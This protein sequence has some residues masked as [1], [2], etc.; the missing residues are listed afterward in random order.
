MASK[1]NVQSIET[2]ISNL[3]EKL[4]PK[5]Q[6][7]DNNG[8]RCG[9]LERKLKQADGSVLDMTDNRKQIRDEIADIKSN[10]TRQ[11]HEELS[12]V[13]RIYDTEKEYKS[14]MLNL[15]RN[16]LNKLMQ[17]KQNIDNDLLLKQAQF[18]AVDKELKKRDESGIQS[19]D[20]LLKRAQL[21]EHELNDPTYY[22]MDSYKLRM[23]RNRLN[24]NYDL[25]QDIKA[26]MI[27]KRKLKFDEQQNTINNEIKILKAKKKMIDDQIRNV[28]NK[29]KQFE[30]QPVNVG[31]IPTQNDIDQ[32]QHK[33]QQLQLEF[34]MNHR[35]KHANIEQEIDIKCNDEMHVMMRQFV[36]QNIISPFCNRYIVSKS[37]L[38]DKSS[39]IEAE[40]IEIEQE[41]KLL[42][43]KQKQNELNIVFGEIEMELIRETTTEM[44]KHL[45]DQLNGLKRYCHTMTHQVLLNSIAFGNGNANAIDSDVIQMSNKCL[46]QLL[47][48]RDRRNRNTSNHRFVLRHNVSKIHQN[49]INSKPNDDLDEKEKPSEMDH[50]RRLHQ[51][52]QNDGMCLLFLC[53]MMAQFSCRKYL[54]EEAKY[55][56]QFINIQHKID[57]INK[58]RITSQWRDSYSTNYTALIAS[59]D[60]HLVVI[61]TH[62]GEI[63]LYHIA[64]KSIIAR[65]HKTQRKTELNHS[66]I[67][68]LLM[69]SNNKMIVSLTQTGIVCVYKVEANI[70]KQIAILHPEDYYRPSK[71]W[72]KYETMSP[73]QL[74]AHF[75]TF[76][77]FHSCLLINGMRPSIMIGLR[78]GTIVKWNL[79]NTNQQNM[80]ILYAPCQT[81]NEP[82][83]SLYSAISSAEQTKWISRE[84]FEYHASEI[85]FIGFI[86]K[87]SKIMLS[88]DTNGVCCVWFYD[89]KSWADYG[90]GWFIPKHKYNIDLDSFVK[91]PITDTEPKILYDSADASIKSQKYDAFIRQNL[92][93][94]HVF[95]KFKSNP[96]QKEVI[97]H[98]YFAKSIISC[99]KYDQES[100]PFVVDSLVYSTVND[101]LIRHMQRSYYQKRLKGTICGAAFCSNHK[102]VIIAI[103]LKPYDDDERDSK[104]GIIQFRLI[105]YDETDIISVDRFIVNIQQAHTNDWPVWNVSPVLIPPCSDYLY[106]LMSNNLRIYSIHTSQEV[107]NIKHCGSRNNPFCITSNHEY[108]I[109]ANQYQTDKAD[110]NNHCLYLSQIV[111]SN[112]TRMKLDQIFTKVVNAKQCTR[113]SRTN[114]EFRRQKHS[115]LE[116]NN[117]HR[118]KINQIVQDIVNQIH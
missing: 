32:M 67:I 72:T 65:T 117:D 43:R 48:D 25:Q 18:N 111:D 50:K 116:Y 78:N 1:E 38:T 87:L 12:V 49:N 101:E 20:M 10:I 51:K 22:D 13:T 29:R 90:S 102:D 97:E 9:S 73:Q 109:F 66:E 26:E 23:A 86:N 106:V 88:I 44:C 46:Q 108:L 54:Q 118:I 11:K 2:L 80:R 81:D 35:H 37:D 96:Q 103:V 62:I 17:K 42:T 34:D 77:A 99:S 4:L 93:Q 19:V 114:W 85:C 8:N 47:M 69:S 30:L 94:T 15:K 31:I 82:F 55:W 98:L 7:Y 6:G 14:E 21:L 74:D 27:E 53:E 3:R 33:I 95:W 40:T 112:N 41:F 115:F 79:I 83:F 91:T 60:S 36:V 64:S 57:R 84:Y 5:Q 56:K 39:W 105:R 61:G 75:V 100:K 76:I 89:S 28:E 110:G 70:I 71:K 52:Y 24:N 63:L 92:R 104:R 113:I 107:L 59:D 45:L 58:K 16:A 68:Q